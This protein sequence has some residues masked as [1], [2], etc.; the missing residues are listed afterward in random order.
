MVKKNFV[1]GLC[2]INPMKRVAVVFVALWCAMGA[3][4]QIDFQLHYDF[5]RM[6][7]PQRQSDRQKVTATIEQFRPDRLGSIY[8]FVDFDFYSKGMKGAYLEFSREFKLVKG[9]AAHIEYNGGVTTGHDSEYGNQFQHC[10]LVGPA[11]NMASAD[12]RRTLS[13][14]VL[15]KQYFKSNDNVN[16]ASFQ[17]TGVWGVQFGRRDMFTFSGYVDLWLNRKFT[18]GKRNLIVATEPQFW[19]NFDG[20]AGA[21]KTGLSIGTEWEISNNFIVPTYGDRTF[22]VNPTVALKWTL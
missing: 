8:W 22:Y 20:I 15:Y 17:L 21:R 6:L 7:Y 16:Y 4:A 12:F 2:P 14:Q 9:L 5:G 18:D 3:M 10:L 1:T 11:Y 13:F 19:F